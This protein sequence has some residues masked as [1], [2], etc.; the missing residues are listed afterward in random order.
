MEYSINV[1]TGLSS[2]NGSGATSSTRILIRSFALS[3]VSSVENPYGKKSN[4]LLS[5]EIQAARVT[6]SNWLYGAA[7]GYERF[8]AKAS[9]D[10]IFD[11]WQN[12]RYTTTGN[13]TIRSS[14]INVYPFIGKRFVASDILIDVSTGVDIAYCLDSR[15]KAEAN[16]KGSSPYSLDYDLNKGSSFFTPYAKKISVDCR[17]RLQIKAQYKKYGL[18][19]GYSQGLTNYKGNS[20]SKVFSRF[21][22][23]GISYQIK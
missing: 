6:K 23:L 11:E 7:L 22:R 17:A 8:A 18:L 2:F 1:F 5:G 15:L 4:T 10:S 21:L 14:F 3:P 9:I 20:S 13:A 12:Q 16:T 19:V